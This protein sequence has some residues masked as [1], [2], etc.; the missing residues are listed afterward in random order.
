MN[1]TVCLILSVGDIHLSF[2]SQQ[3]LI[4][5]TQFYIRFHVDLLYN[6]MLHGALRTAQIIVHSFISIIKHPLICHIVT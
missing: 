1:V 5:I 6:I 2:V 4:M 3:T